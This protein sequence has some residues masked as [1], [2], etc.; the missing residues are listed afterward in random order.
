MILNIKFLSLFALVFSPYA[1]S[2]TLDT[3]NQT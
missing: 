3:L 2:N 1:Q